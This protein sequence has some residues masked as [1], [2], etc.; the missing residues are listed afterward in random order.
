M[1]CIVCMDAVICTACAIS[2]DMVCILML[3]EVQIYTREVLV[4]IICIVGVIYMYTNAV[5]FIIDAKY[6]FMNEVIC[7]C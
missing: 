1:W 7:I 3:L 2:Y 5:I 4:A 6:M